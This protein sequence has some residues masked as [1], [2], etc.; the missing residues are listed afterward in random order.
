[1]TNISIF[2]LYEKPF[3]SPVVCAQKV[4]STLFFL[5]H[6]EYIDWALFLSLLFG[7][8][9]ART[10]NE[11]IHM[12]QHS[13][14]LLNEKASRLGRK[15]SST[16]TTSERLTLADDARK[17]CREVLRLYFV[18]ETRYQYN[19]VP[20]LVTRITD[21]VTQRLTQEAKLPRKYVVHCAI[22]QRNGAGMHAISSCSWNPTSDA[23]FVEMMDNKA[24]H[25]IV[26]VYGIT[27]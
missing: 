27:L 8:K 10:V 13:A 7:G 4:L 16:P 1:M 9:L 18:P 17:I 21:Q 6:V 20:A 2:F 12:N 22:M 23:C 5:C 14:L 11:S 19:K 15:E 24:M 26:T 3:S 25:C